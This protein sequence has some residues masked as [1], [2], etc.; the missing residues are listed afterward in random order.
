MD[1]HPHENAGYARHSGKADYPGHRW[2][3]MK[4]A[5]FFSALF[6]AAPACAQQV[7]PEPI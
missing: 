1:Y 3:R 4:I 7:A 2:L 5:I 6:V